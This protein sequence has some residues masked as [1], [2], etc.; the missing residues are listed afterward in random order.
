M[1]TFFIVLN[2]YNPVA[3]NKRHL[4]EAA[5]TKEAEEACEKTGEPFIIMKSIGFCQRQVVWS[6][7]EP[8]EP[9]KDPN[10]SII[11]QAEF[12]SLVQANQPF[13]QRIRRP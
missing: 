10:K 2:K 4:S 1:E 12:D 3:K 5:A 13:D 9:F 7:T 6:S 11:S 8:A